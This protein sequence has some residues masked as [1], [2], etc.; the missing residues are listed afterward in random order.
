MGKMKQALP[1]LIGYGVSITLAAARPYPIPPPRPLA[2][3]FVHL[4]RNSDSAITSTLKEL[5]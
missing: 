1:G 3:L 4:P 2:E 5:A